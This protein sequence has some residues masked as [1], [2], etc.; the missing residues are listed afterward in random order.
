MLRSFVPIIVILA[1]SS[2]SLAPA[3]AADHY[4]EKTVSVQVTDAN[5]K[6]MRGIPVELWTKD[7]DVALKDR[8]D[9]KG[10]LEFRHMPSQKCFLEVLPPIKNGWLL[11]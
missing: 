8:T 7:G 2:G 9:G 1:A 10:R 4:G 11:R 3:L 5:G 6:P